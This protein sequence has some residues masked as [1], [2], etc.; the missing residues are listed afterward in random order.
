MLVSL[1]LIAAS[2]ALALVAPLL[3]TSGHWQVFRPRLALGLWFGSFAGGIAIV[4]AALLVSIGAAVAAAEHAAGSFVAS[5]GAW[6]AVLATAGGLAAISGLSEP[7]VDSYHRSLRRISPVA[8]SREDRGS[9]TLVRFEADQPVAI[10]VSGR[11]PEILVSSMMEESLT[12]PQLRA[13]LAHE[14]AHLRGHHGILVRLTEL[15]AAFL[16]GWLP[17]G[18]AFRRATRLLVELIADDTAARQAGSEHLR[19]AL[20]KLGE[21]TGESSFEVRSQRLHR[22]PQAKLPARGVPA[23]VRI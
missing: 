6:L 3:L 22:L 12:L 8:I 16:P 10:A 21:L 15:N 9:F 2:A 5:L 23:P 13:V 1:A 11:H 4:I 17:A 19:S 20:K 14:Y 18:R 7:L